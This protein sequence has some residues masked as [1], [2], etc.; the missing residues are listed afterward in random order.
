MVSWPWFFGTIL[1]MF[2][3]YIVAGLAAVFCVV[4]AF[5]NKAL[6]VG[7]GV[8]VAIESGKDDVKV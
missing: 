6:V 2:W 7:S 5:V 4:V 1:V 3:K 8:F